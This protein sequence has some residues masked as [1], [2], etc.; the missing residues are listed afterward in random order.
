MSGT[1]MGSPGSA[2]VPDVHGAV[3][4]CLSGDVQDVPISEADRI[5]EITV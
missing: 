2:G 1:T 5:M 3:E 4:G